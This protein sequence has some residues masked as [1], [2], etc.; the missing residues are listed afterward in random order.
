[1]VHMHGQKLGYATT[2]RGIV[3]TLYDFFM[4]SERENERLECLI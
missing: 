3:T 4:V 2:G 1:M